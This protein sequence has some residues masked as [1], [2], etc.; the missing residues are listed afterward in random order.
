M[1]KFERLDGADGIRGLACLI[2]LLTHGVGMFFISATTRHLAG[3]G[4][5]LFFVLSALLLTKKFQTTGFGPESLVSYAV[6]RVLRILPL[7]IIAV[8]VHKAF[9]ALGIVAWSDVM[10]A[11]TFEK[12]Y[13]HLWTVPVEFTFYLWLP[14]VALAFVAARARS[15]LTACGLLVMLLLSQQLVWPYWNTPINA[16]GTGWY[17]SSFT[18]GCFL[19][20][21]LNDIRPKITDRL[22]NVLAI[23]VMLGLFLASPGARH[24]LFGVPLDYAVVDKFVYI[25]AAWAIF[26]VATID[27]KGVFGRLVRRE[28]MRKLGAWSYSLY[29]FHGLVLV[30]I[31]DRFPNNIFAMLAGIAVAV[32]VGAASFYVIESPIERYRQMLQRVLSAKLSSASAA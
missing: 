8:L 18:I 1:E 19:A 17:A 15:I 14:I 22:A 3:T 4:K 9:G 29:L 16:L 11:L 2:V 28:F 20:V 24:E 5:W 23:S 21:T 32:A 10:A 12:G 31:A 26:I 30:E 27:G 13:A 25:S 7:F 6:G